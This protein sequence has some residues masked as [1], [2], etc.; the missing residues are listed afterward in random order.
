[1]THSYL[2]SA[3]GPQAKHREGHEGKHQDHQAEQ[4][5][6]RVGIKVC[7]RPE[8]VH[9]AHGVARLDLSDLDRGHYPHD[10]SGNGDNR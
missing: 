1:M 4:R 9:E 5:L 3:V 8:G 10:P 7:V 2:D 6:P